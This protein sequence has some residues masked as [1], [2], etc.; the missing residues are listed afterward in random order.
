M[1][2]A[3]SMELTV[4]SSTSESGVSTLTRLTGDPQQ[5]D[6]ETQIRRYADGK[7]SPP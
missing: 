3:S 6:W 1:P 4:R 2:R 5:G 7:A